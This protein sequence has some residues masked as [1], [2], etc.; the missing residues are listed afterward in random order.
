MLD[1]K[2]KPKLL[3]VDDDELIRNALSKLLRQEFNIDS[4]DDASKVVESITN[5]SYDVVLSDIEMPIMTGDE[6]YF[7][8]KEKNEKMS[9]R[10]LFMTGGTS[11]KEAINL[12]KKVNWVPKPF[13]TQKLK[14]LLIEKTKC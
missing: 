10:I 14:N 5:G 12:L 6:M 7:L 8:V 9:K 11:R 13:D 4:V 2:T 3:I 1:Q